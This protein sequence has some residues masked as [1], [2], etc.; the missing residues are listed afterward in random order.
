MAKRFLNLWE[1]SLLNTYYRALFWTQVLFG[2]PKD[3]LFIVFDSQDIVYIYMVGFQNVFSQN[4]ALVAIPWGPASKSPLNFN[5]TQ[6][7]GML[8]MKACE[9]QKL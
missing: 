6:A 8:N 1:P 9:L 5:H 4:G 2:S 3:N 7:T